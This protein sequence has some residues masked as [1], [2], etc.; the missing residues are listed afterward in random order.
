M[1]TKGEM[2]DVR[3]REQQKEGLTERMAA[4]PRRQRAGRD[5]RRWW[6][7]RYAPL[8][9]RRPW[10]LSP[11][12][13]EQMRPLW[14]FSGY[15]QPVEAQ[16]QVQWDGLEFQVTSAMADSSITKVYVQVRDLEGT[17]W[18]EKWEV[19]GLIDGG[20]RQRQPKAEGNS[21]T[22]GGQSVRAMRPRPKPPLLEFSAGAVTPPTR[23]RWV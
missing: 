5:V 16:T 9:P 21:Y 22:F 4:Q 19:M 12:W 18:R 15:T 3:L 8:A 17:G 14:G 10:L 23:E 20:M 11:T 13:W 1:T 2:D 7:R 6:L